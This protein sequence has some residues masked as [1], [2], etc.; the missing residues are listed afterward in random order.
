M[1]L[2]SLFRKPAWEHR[3]PDRR[4]AA[5]ASQ[6]HPDLVA[7][8]PELARQD[9]DA[10]VRLA[11]LRR[12]DDLSLLGDR[13]RNDAD[14]G[15]RSLARQ[16]YL[17]HL[18]DPALVLAERERVLAVEEDAEIL[19]AVAQQAPEAALR[20]LGLERSTRPGLLA[21]RCVKDPDPQLRQWLLERID[22]L[23]VLER[24]AERARKT[25]KRLARRARERIQAARLAAGD[26]E[27]V[28]ARAL[29]ICEVLDALRHADADA[30][31]RDRAPLWTEW[32][33]LKPALDAATERR[34]E[35]YFAALDAA[36]APPPPSAA[37]AAELPLPEPEEAPAAHPPGR[38]PDLALSALLTELEARCARL[39]LRELERLEQRWLERLRRIEP[40]HP[41]ER[42]QEARFRACAS[43]RRR[44]LEQQAQARAQALQTL[45]DEISALEQALQAGQVAVARSQRQAIAA[46]CTLLGEALPRTLARRLGEATRQLDRLG[47]WQHW[48]GNKARIGL[49][50][51]VEALAGSGLHPDA[52]AA[53]VKQ[54]QGQ[55][56]QLDETDARGTEHPLNRRFR[57]VCHQVLAPARPY[58]EKRRELRGAQREAI[59]AGQAQIEAQLQPPPPPR[60]LRG[61]RRQLLDLLRQCEALEPSA[62]R[63][64]GRS[65]RQ[66][67]GRIDALLAASE[68]EGEAGKRKLLSRL[69][70]ELPQAGLDAAL[71]LAREAQAQWKQLPRAARE[72]ENALW[73]E[74]REL[75]E[76]WFAQA[77]ARQQQQEEALQARTAAAAEVLEELERLAAAVDEALP[78]IEARLHALQTRWRELDTAARETADATVSPG[79]GKTARAARA[80]FR[81]G[82]DERAFERAAAR[83]QALCADKARRAHV[84]ELRAIVEAGQLCDQLEALAPDARQAQTDLRER[85]AALALAADARAALRTRL[86]AVLAPEAAASDAALAT[87]SGQAGADARAA[88]LTVLA[89]LACDRPSPEEARELRRRLQIERLSEHLSGAAADAAGLRPL[90]LRYAS[91]CGVSPGVRAALAPRWQALMSD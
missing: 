89:E 23:A 45:P 9:P 72:T 75:V 62:R 80:G 57:A 19:A 60:E 68:A 84:A 79:A 18:L 27:A 70:R 47:Q 58:F 71:R 31:K 16:R 50:E 25:D 83:V 12:I 56:Q 42:E 17:H 15:V 81:S 7:R 67:L 5:V 10:P 11:A 64:L 55:W 66:G 65:L 91:L 14:A 22:D 76:P 8:L 39:N 59:Q 4:A 43:Q 2:F 32:Q 48:S 86:D 49:I 69:R 53:K 85:F 28:Q 74:L 88:E 3:D 90:L 1:S 6:T 82:L 40:L 24:I 26:P 78:L 30:A 46:R 41:V 51:A 29:A 34:V 77:D 44:E 35:G 33:A 37:T 21:E 52:L 20:R 13:M 36:L 61:L 54:Y 63:D 38:E 87:A 73:Q